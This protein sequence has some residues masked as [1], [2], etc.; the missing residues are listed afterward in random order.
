MLGGLIGISVIT[1][2]RERRVGPWRS[3]LRI[4]RRVSRHRRADIARRHRRAAMGWNRIIVIIRR[5]RIITGRWRI[6]AA[7]PRIIVRRGRIIGLRNRSAHGT[8]NGTANDQ[9]DNDKSDTNAHDEVPADPQKTSTV[10]AQLIG[11]EEGNKAKRSPV[12]DECGRPKRGCDKIWITIAERRLFYRW[13][14]PP[15]LITYS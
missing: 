13:A 12:F 3:R 6:V 1:A 5:R 4:A 11:R 9:R 2:A 8:A 15:Q 7:R 10:F 14:R